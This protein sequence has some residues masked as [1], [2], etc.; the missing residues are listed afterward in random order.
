MHVFAR[1]G[2]C[3]NMVLNVARC[4]GDICTLSI[5][6]R[7]KHG[8][9]LMVSVGWLVSV[10]W[11]HA[12]V[13]RSKLYENDDGVRQHAESESTRVHRAR[14]ECQIVSK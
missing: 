10:P 1:H 12:D 5:T 11:F 4:A 6:S 3:N 7:L 9:Y 13:N 2:Y 14:E 8:S